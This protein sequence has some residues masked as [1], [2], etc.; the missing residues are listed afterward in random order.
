MQSCRRVLSPL[1]VVACVALLASSIG[2]P[3]ASSQAQAQ[4]TGSG[5]ASTLGTAAGSGAAGGTASAGAEGEEDTEEATGSRDVLAPANLG[6]RRAWLTTRLDAVVAKA[7]KIPN[8]RLSAIVVDLH[9]AAPAAAPVWSAEPDLGQ[10]LASATKLLTSAAALSALGPGFRWRTSLA[11]ESFDKTTGVVTGN[12]Y[13]RGRGDPT[14]SYRDLQQLAA[15]LHAAGVRKVTGTL[16]VDASYFDDVLLP[17]HFDEQP[18]ERA[19]YRAANAAFSVERNA[20]TVV[21]EPGLDAAGKPVITLDP[22]VTETYVVKNPTV[23]TVVEG[24]SAIKIEPKTVKKR[25]E[26]TLSGQIRAAAGFDYTRFRVDEPLRFAHDAM[27]AALRSRGIKVSAAFSTG[28]A[29]TTAK[30]IVSH[31]STTLADVVRTMN[32]QSDNFIAEAVFKTLGA[33]TKG[34]PRASW[35]DATTAVRNYL[36]GTAKV[37]GTWRADNGSGLYNASEMSARQLAAVLVAARNDER[38]AIDFAASLPIA[39]LDG[40]LAKRFTASL[41]KGLVR[42]KTG[43]LDN[44]SALAGYAGTTNAPF[45]FVVLVNKFAKRDRKAVRALQDEIAE[46]IVAFATAGGNR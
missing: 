14:L 2:L 13:V 24:R 30:N 43:T 34:A 4:P 6:A 12:L 16:V 29:P 36:R 37:P 40:T 20:I 35:A 38:I 45:G 5:S 10:N 21:V 8:A 1:L 18:N 28:T 31:D 44:V 17:P 33:Q 15:D 19:G 26:L 39:G 9:A 42:A 22:P 23:V 27:R 7:S 11:A 25:V 3:V 46:L 41:A 32:K